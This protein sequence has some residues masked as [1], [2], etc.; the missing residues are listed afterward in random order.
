MTTALALPTDR[1][2]LTL[3]LDAVVTGLVG[4]LALESPLAWYDAPAW[5]VRGVGVLLLVVGADLALLSRASGRL[6][7]VGT[8]VMTE[9]AFAWVLATAAVLVWRDVP[10]EGVEVLGAVGL[11]TLGFGLAYTRLARRA[12]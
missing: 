11:V 5:L 9:L 12:R 10:A 8:V 6:L 2:R 4:V 1:L 3:Q 7:R